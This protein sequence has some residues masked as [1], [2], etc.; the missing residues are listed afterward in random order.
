MN[1]RGWPDRFYQAMI[2]AVVPLT[3]AEQ[4]PAPQR[5]PSSIMPWLYCA[6]PVDQF[7]YLLPHMFPGLLPIPPPS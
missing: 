3:V 6:M 4:Y 7:V 2:Q 1:K 5:S